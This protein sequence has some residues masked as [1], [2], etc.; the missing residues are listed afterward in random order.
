MNKRLQ[1]L[2]C[3]ANHDE[4]TPADLIRL[5]P[6]LRRSTVYTTMA[7][8]EGDKW[9]TSRTEKVTSKRTRPLRYYS[10]TPLGRQGLELAQ[11]Q[12]LA[13]PDTAFS[14]PAIAITGTEI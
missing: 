11:A 8:L 6:E 4:L 13:N 7:R 3:L 14:Q 9:L 2:E 12:E 10:I 5:N 1:I